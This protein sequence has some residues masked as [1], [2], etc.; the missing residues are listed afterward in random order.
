MAL[1]MAATLAAVGCSSSSSG[2]ADASVSA[3]GC[4]DPDP[5]PLDFVDNMED[6][7]QLV[8]GRDGRNGGWY[9]F[10]DTT[11]G[12]LN[13]DMGQPVVM[14]TIPGGRCGTSTHAMRVTGSGFSEWG[15]GF[16]FGFKTMVTN[17]VYENA[18][19]DVSAARGIT[20]WA[21]KGE[22]SVDSVRL[23]IGDQ[24]SVPQGGH[25]DLTVTLGPTACWDH[26]TAPVPLTTTWKRYTFQF[27]ELQQRNFGIP[28]PSLDL[29][30]VY[31]V[32]FVMPMSAPV[33]D[34]WVD[35]VALF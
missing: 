27:G 16:G 15:S 10:K 19:Y 1:V 4:T 32:E 28:R 9:T 21:R 7:D 33:F 22:T 8:L 3:L 31:M 26:F 14:E 6:G 23:G 18:R 13:P 20:F 34:I 24:W 17:G 35:D 29:A 25:C 5:G 11:A 12:T 2:P 30:N